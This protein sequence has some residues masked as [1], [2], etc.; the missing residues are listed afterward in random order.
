MQIVR[1]AFEAEARRD[2]AAL[3]GLYDPEVEMDFAGSP[4]ADFAGP[5]VR[6]GSNEVRDAFRDFYVSFDAVESDLH[7][8]IDAG[9]DVVSVFT[10]RGRGRTSGV[11][12][13]WRDMAGVWTLRGGKI[14]R[15]TWLRSREQA[16]EAARLGSP[17]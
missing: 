5:K 10:Y 13:E 17:E 2:L 7:E 11:E 6:R 12:T 9:E 8:L 4:F 3:H 15:V 16:I 14:I 1:D